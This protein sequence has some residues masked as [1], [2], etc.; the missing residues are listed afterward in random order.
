MHSKVEEHSDKDAVVV[1]TADVIRDT[2]KALLV[3]IGE[4]E[5]WIPQSQIHADS[6]VYSL[7]TSGGKL[8]VSKWIAEQ[9]GLWESDT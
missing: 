3:R 8:I 5:H 6:E 9:R 7:S 4:G 1:G 2:G